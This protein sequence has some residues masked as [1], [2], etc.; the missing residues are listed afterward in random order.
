VLLPLGYN[1]PSQKEGRDVNA[2]SHQTAQVDFVYTIAQQTR[3]TES[4]TD[5]FNQIKWPARCFAI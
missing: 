1:S 4:P 2:D 3:I 5:S